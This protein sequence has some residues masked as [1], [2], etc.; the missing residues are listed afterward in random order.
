MSV[1]QNEAYPH[2]IMHEFESYLDKRQARSPTTT[3]HFET[4]HIPESVSLRDMLQSSTHLCNP[5]PSNYLKNFSMSSRDEQNGYEK[6]FVNDIFP[7]L[8]YVPT[9]QNNQIQECSD[10][11]P[12]LGFNFG[13]FDMNVIRKQ[14]EST[15]TDIAKRSMWPKGPTRPCFC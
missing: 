7:D 6:P 15:I 11:V 8:E 13:K 2:A 1:P 4:E 10:K 14:L 9:K 5:D 12:V 3:L